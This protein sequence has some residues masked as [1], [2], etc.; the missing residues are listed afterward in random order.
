MTTT[1]YKSTD[2]SAPN[3]T[4]VA[5]SIITLLDAVLVNGYGAKAGLGWTKAFSGVNKA[6][7]QQGAG[8]G[9]RYLRIDDTTVAQVNGINGLNSCTGIDDVA[10]AFTS[11][12]P[13]NLTFLKPT[14][15]DPFSAKNIPK[16]VV[17]GNEKSFWLFVR[18]CTTISDCYYANFFGDI[19]E[20]APNVTEQTCLALFQSSSNGVYGTVENK[21]YAQGTG[22]E[23]SNIKSTSATNGSEPA[24]LTRRGMQN[25]LFGYPNHLLGTG[26]THLEFDVS[27]DAGATPL[28]TLPALHLCPHT[29]SDTRLIASW[30][31]VAGDGDYS[32]KTFETVRLHYGAD[33]AN[34]FIYLIEVSDTWDN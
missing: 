21:I 10:G 4:E 26:L 32:G 3:I 22:C 8:S 24:I 12:S 11:A 25:A 20:T 27:A 17:V 18:P 28:G 34:P 23:V 6:V 5:G 9:A 19:Y 30:Q 13:A 29:R 7:Y 2:A 16:W 31:S 1:I 15:F 33:V 14:A